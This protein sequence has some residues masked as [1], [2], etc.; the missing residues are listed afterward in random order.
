MT[1]TW[2]PSDKDAGI[3]LSGGNLIAT[4][5]SGQVYRTLRAT[6]AITTGQKKVFELKFTALPTAPDSNAIGIANASE[7]LSDWL[8][9]STVASRSVGHFDHDNTVYGFG[10]IGTTTDQWVLNDWVMIA[11]DFD[12]KLIW[13][14]VGAAGAWNGGGTANPATGVG[15]YTF[16][17][18]GDV[19]P[20]ATTSSGAGG[21]GT[22]LANFGATAFNRTAPAGFTGFDSPPTTTDPLFYLRHKTIR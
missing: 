18:T 16:T 20:A 21:N 5:S 11:T 10:N 19:F 13:F 12:A 14:A 8:G 17:C 2:N 3:A 4:G 15:G 6:T 9:N 22:V 1:T 7:V